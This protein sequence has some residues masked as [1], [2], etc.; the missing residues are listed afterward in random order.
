MHVLPTASLKNLHSG[1]IPTGKHKPILNPHRPNPTL[2]H[3][4]TLINFDLLGDIELT[5][6]M[7]ACCIVKV[8]RVQGCL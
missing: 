2:M 8:V 3:R 5:D 4:L 6:C 1:I 7:L